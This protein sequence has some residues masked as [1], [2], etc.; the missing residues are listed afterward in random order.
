MSMQTGLNLPDSEIFIGWF[1]LMVHLGFTEKTSALVV[2]VLVVMSI[3]VSL[4]VTYKSLISIRDYSYLKFYKL[5][6]E[7]GQPI[8][9]GMEAKL[10]QIKFSRGWGFKCPYMMSVQFE[11]VFPKVKKSFPRE[12]FYSTVRWLKVERG[13]LARVG[14]LL[15]SV[16][17]VMLTGTTVI[18]LFIFII[19]IYL[20]TISIA[21]NE[22]KN[23]YLLLLSVFYGYIVKDG[24]QVLLG[25]LRAKKLIE[26]I[27]EDNEI[28]GKSTALSAI[29]EIVCFNPSGHFNEG[30]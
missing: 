24:V 14:K 2:F 22:L 4:Y 8:S 29:P 10:E 11:T 7:L 5:V 9:Y 3:L 23:I 13:Q 6:K 1:E 27:T 15:R 30:I 18:S 19:F 25:Y 21:G 28:V 16:D 12:H 26:L 17:L 20:A